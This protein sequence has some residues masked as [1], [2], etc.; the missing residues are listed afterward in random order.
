[1]EDECLCDSLAPSL[2]LFVLTWLI[3]GQT[4]EHL[5]GSTEL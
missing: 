5:Y 2:E 1:M 3:W 4:A